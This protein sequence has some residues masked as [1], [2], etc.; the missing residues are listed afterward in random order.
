MINDE[1]D[2]VIKELFDSL[3]NRYQNNLK[4][5]KGSEFVFDYVHLLYYK[6]HKIN[7]SRGDRNKKLS[8]EEYLNKIRPYLKDIVNLKKS[9]IW[10]IQLKIAKNF[11]SSIDNDEE[12]V[13]HSKSYNIEIMINDEADEVIKELFDSLKNRYQNNL[14]SV[15][16]SEFVF[17]YVHLLYYK[18]HKINPSRG[19]SYVDSPDWIKKKKKINLIYKKDNK[20]FQYAITV[21][22]NHEEIKKDPQRKTKNKS[23]INKCNWEGI[24]FPSE[25]DDR[26]KF[27]KNNVTIALNV[28][29]AKNEKIY[30]SYV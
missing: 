28:L 16:G 29:Y 4:S 5:V 18:F 27:E 6:F 11:I 23:L 30:P 9:D 14:K 21:V 19:G 24:S 15:K 17:D 3:K 26:K 20:C 12:Y 13:M 25:K 10:K 2:E 7:P 1:A 22:L 8:V